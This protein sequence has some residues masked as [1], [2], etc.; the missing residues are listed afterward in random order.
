MLDFIGRIGWAKFIGQRDAPPAFSPLDIASLRLWLDS[1]DLATITK[2]GSDQVSAWDDKSGNGLDATG[3]GNP[4]YTT[5][6]GRPCMQLSGSNNFNINNTSAFNFLHNGSGSTVIVVLNITGADAAYGLVGN[7]SAGANRGIAIAT[8]ATTRKAQVIVS[9]GGGANVFNAVSANNGYVSSQPARW[10]HRN[11]NNPSG[12]DYEL[13]F[14]DTKVLHGAASGTFN[15]S[16]ASNQMGIGCLATS[17]ARLVG[18]IHEVFFFADWLSD[19]DI[20]LMY[21]YI[22]AKWN[23]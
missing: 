16:D 4:L 1:A 18:N 3:S 19:A 11:K 21:A 8:A 23:L 17:S 22:D 10:M 20:A 5:V 13:W 7:R 15:A 6:S 2:N 9:E 12:D 14:N